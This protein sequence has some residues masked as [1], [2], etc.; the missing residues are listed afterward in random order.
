MRHSSYDIGFRYIAEQYVAEVD[1]YL[2]QWLGFPLGFKFEAM[3]SPKFYNFETDRVFAYVE[4]ETVARL[5]ALSQEDQHQALKAKIQ[6]RFTSRDG[7]IS[8]YRNTLETWL[9]KPI[10]N[11]DH[12]ELG[13]LLLACLDLRAT[14]CP[15]DPKQWDW[16]I[17]ENMYE[18]FYTAIDRQTDWTAFEASMKE[19]RE[20][21]EAELRAEDPDY[22]APAYRCPFTLDLFARQ[23]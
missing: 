20:D 17:F 18:D 9:A 14:D 10:E 1:H 13:T 5:F 3:D 11:W 2:S 12:N 4:P 16:A 7:F 6:E 21:K 22:V 8:G 15:D 23:P 19:A